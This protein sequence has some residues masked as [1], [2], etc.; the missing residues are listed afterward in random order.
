MTVVVCLAVGHGCNGQPDTTH[1]IK[2]DTWKEIPL[3]AQD[4]H[5]SDEEIL[6]SL[7][8]D[9]QGDAKQVGKL[10]EAF[11]NPSIAIFSIDGEGPGP[12]GE[13]PRKS[14]AAGNYVH[15]GHHLR[16]YPILRRAEVE[17]AIGKQNI[18]K[19]LKSP[20]LFEKEGSIPLCFDPGMAIRLTQGDRQLDVVICLKCDGIEYFNAF[21][22]RYY[23][24]LSGEGYSQLQMIYRNAGMMK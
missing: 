12:D 10:F 17:S 6:K 16:G 24:V 23:L 13:D 21:E 3:R 18:I 2:I 8:E 19:V 5:R 15:D 20:L 4:D 1:A 14:D 9:V 22:S 7:P 11:D